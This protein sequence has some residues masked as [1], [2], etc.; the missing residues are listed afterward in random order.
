MT[1]VLGGSLL[2]QRCTLRMPKVPSIGQL[3]LDAS[4]YS[5][6]P[7]ETQK[8][9]MRCNESSVR[10]PRRAVQ[11]AADKQQGGQGR[12]INIRHQCHVGMGP[13]SSLSIHVT[14]NEE[15]RMK[16]RVVGLGP[17]GRPQHKQDA[18]SCRD[19]QAYTQLRIRYRRKPRG[20]IAT[21]GQH[22]VVSGFLS[23]TS[24]TFPESPM[25]S[26]CVESGNSGFPAVIPLTA[27]LQ[28]YRWH[29]A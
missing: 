27:S 16:K 6:Q 12:K 2:G 11:P 9:E 22:S 18:N 26:C 14:E 10:Q 7:H 29:A 19:M 4:E 20:G 21:L 28:V 5:T 3:R 1:G 17:D 8:G 13:K 23:F 24:Q 25:G 15:W